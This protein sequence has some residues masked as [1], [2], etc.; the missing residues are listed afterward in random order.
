[1]LL[2]V[3]SFSLSLFVLACQT[4]KSYEDP[5][6][7]EIIGDKFSVSDMNIA[8]AQLVKDLTE[9]GGFRNWQ[10]THDKPPFVLLD[11]LQNQTSEID[12]PVQ[13][14][15]DNIK[16]ELIRSGQVRFIDGALR[17]RLLEEYQYQA[18]G[19]VK[20][21]EVKKSGSQISPDLFLTGSVSSL[22]SQEKGMKSVYYQVSIRA[23]NIETSEIISV[24]NAKIK[25]HFNKRRF[26]F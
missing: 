23:T 24:S 1:M 20:A 16:N 19:T 11:R 4:S 25:K 10:S 18:S 26:S 17:D 9:Q 14:I 21:N 3:F 5:S 13:M 15:N 12:L 6:S 2:K 7:I 22:V 8:V